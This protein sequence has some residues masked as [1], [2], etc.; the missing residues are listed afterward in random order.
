MRSPFEPV[1][2]TARR[3][4]GRDLKSADLAG[5]TPGPRLGCSCDVFRR[6]RAIWVRT[7]SSR[8]ALPAKPTWVRVT[9]LGADIP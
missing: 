7:C 6:S 8:R 5:S 2:G 1:A 3:V 9:G 4:V